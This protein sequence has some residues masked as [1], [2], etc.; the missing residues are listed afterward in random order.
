MPTFSLISTL[1]TD[2]NPL[3][4]LNKPK[5]RLNFAADYWLLCLPPQSI[6]GSGNGEAHPMRR[7][8]PLEKS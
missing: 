8:I 3:Y 5:I 6:A 4:K 1:F 2:K 7:E